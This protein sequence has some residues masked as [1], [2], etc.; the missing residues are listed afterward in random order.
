V[1]PGVAIAQDHLHHAG[2]IDNCDRHLITAL[3]AV[4]ERRLRKVQAIP[5]AKD[6]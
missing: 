5:G 3:L 4:R 1:R 6:L 2:A